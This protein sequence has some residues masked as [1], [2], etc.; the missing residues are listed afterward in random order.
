MFV[1]FVF[2]SDDLTSIKKT[3]ESGVCSRRAFSPGRE[4]GND[5]A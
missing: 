1:P 3:L 4:N 2:Q 5:E